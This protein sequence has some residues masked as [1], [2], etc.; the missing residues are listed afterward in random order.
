MNEIK[1]AAEVLKI[2]PSNC[3]EGTVHEQYCNW[4][5]VEKA[6]TLAIRVL[7]NL[8]EE[9]VMM[10]IKNWLAKAIGKKWKDIL[11]Y[12]KRRDLSQEIIKSLVEGK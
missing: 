11:V 4:E 5:N 1:Q 2:I 6:K 12:F 8:E 3:L 10:T 7:E 9:K